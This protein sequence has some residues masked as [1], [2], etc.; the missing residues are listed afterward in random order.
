MAKNTVNARIQLKRDTAANWEKQ[1]DFI[2]LLGELVVYTDNHFPEPIRFKIGDGIHTINEL[3]FALSIS[4]S[5]SAY[6]ADKLS[7]EDTGSINQP[8]YFYQGKPYP[9]NYRINKTVP[10]DAVFTDT[11]YRLSLESTLLE[12]DTSLIEKYFLKFINSKK[13]ETII[14]I[15]IVT[16]KS[17]GFMTSDFYNKIINNDLEV[18]WENI[19]N[20]PAFGILAYKDKISL[21]ELDSDL[22]ESK[23][24]ADTALQSIN[25]KVG[26][27]TY[28]GKE[29]EGLIINASDLGLSGAL[30]FHSKI[31]ENE[32]FP[33]SNI[34]VGSVVLKGDK[35]FVY[36]QNNTWVE[37]GDESSYALKATTISG[38]NGLTGGGA[39]DTNIL[40]SHANTSDV[41]NLTPI[42]RTYV[43][44]LT[45]DGFG[46]VTG[47]E[48]QKE[49]VIDTDTGMTSVETTGDGNVVTSA[50]Y[51]SSLRKL[52]L[53]K[54]ASFNDFTYTLPVANYNTLGGVKPIYSST[55]SASF[56]TNSS[57]NN[58]NP[59]IEAKTTI[60]GRYYGVES[61]KDGHLYVNVPWISAV[62]EE[63]IAYRGSDGI[64]IEG[65][66]I[67]HTN[68]ITADQA[69]GG[70]GSLEFGDTIV[71]PSLSY[72]GQGH[73]TKKSTT[74]Y[75]LPSTLGISRLTQT[76]T[77]EL[78]INCN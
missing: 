1:I 33:T 5:D 11:T 55:Q 19:L 20:T 60:S 22:Q 52:T 8:V 13:E 71:L 26:N 59:T 57:S 29:A 74:S 41:N 68:F 10:L 54:E 75:T 12:N 16:E 27:K 30:K 49:T 4:K 73:I 76:D 51:D 48:T 65:D 6:E 53:K 64:T 35:E 3:P 36:T 24:K 40:I 61:D 14:D 72:D 63:G 47:Y 34:E 77:E 56:T 9:I 37:L 58:D 70:S 38:I 67:K 43:T 23:A 15:P 39:L 69:A 2:P 66:L 25:I 78:I 18:K 17:P 44:G 62:A 46:H 21:S 45:F 28:T 42:S 31:G 50:V 32:N 7:V